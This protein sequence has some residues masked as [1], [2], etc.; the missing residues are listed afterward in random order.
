MGFLMASGLSQALK[1]PE[2]PLAHIPMALVGAL[3]FGL[4]LTGFPLTTS[5]HM[6]HWAMHM[7]HIDGTETT[8]MAP[9]LFV[10]G[11][12][13]AA[14]SKTPETPPKTPAATPSFIASLRV[15]YIGVECR[16]FY[17][18]DYKFCSSGCKVYIKRTDVYT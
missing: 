10:S 14:F 12:S 13:A 4:I 9:S 7:P 6:A 15:I 3:V 11:L 1:V 2:T 17:K 5:I 16:Y 8:E 18:A